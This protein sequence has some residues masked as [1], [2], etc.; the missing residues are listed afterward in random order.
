MHRAKQ[1]LLRQ[2]CRGAQK[3][4]SAPSKD[5][6]S[7]RRL[8]DRRPG[9][10]FDSTG[11]PVGSEFGLTADLEGA[12]I[13]PAV[14]ADGSGGFVV[15]WE[16]SVDDSW[17]REILGRR[18]DSLGAPI[19]NPFQINAASTGN[20]LRPAVRWAPDG[21]K[22]LVAWASYA[23]ESAL[24]DIRGRVFDSAG[25]PLT[26]EFQI[27]SVTTERQLSPAVAAGSNDSFLVTW[28]NFYP[29]DGEG[30]SVAGRV[31]HTSGEPL[32]TE[33][34]VNTFT[35]NHQSKPAVTH[36]SG[37]AFVVVWTS[38]FQD[39]DWGGIYGRRVAAPVF[40]DGFESGDHCQWSWSLPVVAGCL[41]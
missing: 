41:R 15:A 40:S 3:P 37:D 10:F 30:R 23:V 5:P 12:H 33:F 38:L 21:T 11:S 34:V 29:S 4:A 13:T 6:G 26:P 32:N 16:N 9:Q 25:S 28:T 20:Q 24:A 14:A 39:G 1:R 35:P 31:V 7:S 36:L 27:N 22:F 19:G 17:N 8:P 2:L 18:L